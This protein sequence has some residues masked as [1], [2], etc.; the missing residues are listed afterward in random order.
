MAA[1]VKHGDI[2]CEYSEQTDRWMAKVDGKNITSDKL[3]VL[4][5]RIDQL[6]APPKV[7]ID[8][9]VYIEKNYGEGYAEGI[10]T[11][12]RADDPNEFSI[13]GA[14]NCTRMG[15]FSIYERSEANKKRIERMRAIEQEI[16]VLNTEKSKLK[17]EM[18]RANLPTGSER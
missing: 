8:M 1:T 10:V 2:E 13:A 11:A 16:K 15:R 3:S 7:R 12:A 4:R 9:P 5:K 14:G 18:Q 17:S 6:L